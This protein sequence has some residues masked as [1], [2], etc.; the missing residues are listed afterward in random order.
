MEYNL[1]IYDVGVRYLLMAFFCILG[2]L[3][4]IYWLM[5]VGVVFF[6][7]AILGACPIYTALGINHAKDAKE[8]YK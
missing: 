6:I 1:S 7:T 3:T 8:D 4:G 2:A 5:G